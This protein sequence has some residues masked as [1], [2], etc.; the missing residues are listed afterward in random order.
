M[1]DRLDWDRDGQDWPNRGAS[2]FVDAAG[3]RWHVQIAGAGPVVLL[4]HG[5]G[6]STHSWAELL[7]MLA[8]RFTVVAP[9]LPG[10]AFTDAGQHSDALSLP[11]MARRVAGLMDALS[12]KPALIAG[13]SAGTAVM[14]RMTLDGLA[15]P[16]GLV[17]INGALF[18]YGGAAAQFFSP[19]A[20]LLVVN[21]WI[22]QVFAWRASDVR[23]VERLIR[24][25][26]SEIPPSNIALY[27]RLFCSSSHVAST[28][29]MMAR[30]DLAA[31][32]A[33]LHRL[34]APLLLLA[35]GA[36]TAISPDE[37]F[38]TRETV[39]G[40]TVEIIRG[41]GHLA[42]EERPD[43]FAERIAAFAE[44]HRL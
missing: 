34:T 40:A 37:A 23:A 15:A 36:D 21:P 20:R 24:G 17:A 44:A 10:H 8:A 5:T 19:L 16:R 42:H 14:L 9:D 4:L 22:P 25:T 30:W 2:R 13:H 38:R 1:S 39:P 35:G 26:G 31:L 6:A 28:L 43:R 32:Q 18:P 11:G 33:D 3:L 27:A 7:P 41:L 12:L 29:A